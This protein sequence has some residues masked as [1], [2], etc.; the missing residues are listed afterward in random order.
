[1]TARRR[2]PGQPSEHAQPEGVGVE[3]GSVPAPV[4]PRHSD[5]APLLLLL[6]P[7]PPWQISGGFGG[8][9]AFAGSTAA[10]RPCPESR[11]AAAPAD[12]SGRCSAPPAGIPGDSGAGTHRGALRAH[13]RAGRAPLCLSPCVRECA[14]DR[15]AAGEEGQKKGRG[16]VAG[17]SF[18][19]EGARR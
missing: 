12:R 7:E 15:R 11:G 9:T 4:M 8:P 13:G 5:A 1:M 17:S 16:R 14:P 10:P 2:S 19:N 3:K 6:P 18:P